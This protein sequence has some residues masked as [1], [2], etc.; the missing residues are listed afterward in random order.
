MSFLNI[1]QEKGIVR[2]ANLVSVDVIEAI[3][4]HLHDFLNLRQCELN[5][6]VA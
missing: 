4:Q 5:V 6:G 3:Q 2:N 1:V